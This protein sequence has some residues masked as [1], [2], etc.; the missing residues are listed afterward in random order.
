MSVPSTWFERD[1]PILEAIIELLN[2][3]RPHSLLSINEVAEHLSRS[4]EEVYAA[5]HALGEEY[6]TLR[7]FL[8]GGDPGPYL[9]TAVTSAAR[10]ASGQ[11]PSEELVIESLIRGVQIAIESETDPEKRSKLKQFLDSAVGVSREVLVGILTTTLTQKIGG[12]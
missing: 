12:I 3:K 1:L 6:I 5:A 11:W 4:K 9:V 8:T 7:E 2:E 10:R